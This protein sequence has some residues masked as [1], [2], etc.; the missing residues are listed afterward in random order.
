[1]DKDKDTQTPALA[2]EEK[3]EAAV[4]AIREYL[5][6][7]AEALDNHPVLRQAFDAPAPAK[8]PE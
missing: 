2:D 7:D 5:N 8:T 3:V 4:Q 6:G 1:M